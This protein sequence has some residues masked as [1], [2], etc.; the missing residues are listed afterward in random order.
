[1]E[2][3]KLCNIIARVLRVDVREITPQSTFAEDLGADSIDGAQILLAIKEEFGVEVKETD[4]KNIKTVSD[5]MNLVKN[6]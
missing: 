1:M 4:V 2:F 5:A 6:A 3:E